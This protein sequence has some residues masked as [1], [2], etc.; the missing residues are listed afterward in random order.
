MSKNGI[1]LYNVIFPVWF[2]LLFPLSWLII[3]PANLLIDSLVLI[4]S[5]KTFK[6]PIKAAWKRAILPVW[7]FGF[8]A[9]ITGAGLLLLTQVVDSDSAVFRWLYE[10]VFN[11]VAFNPFRSIWSV[12]VVLVA[13]AVS[14]IL[15]YFL[16]YKVSFKKLE[17]ENNQK[18]KLAVALAVFTAPWVM[19]IPS[20]WIY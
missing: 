7:A 6:Q 3:L 17:I 20:S 15:I 5:L 9:D 16:N 4:L 10:N 2:L 18:K 1:T 11:Y 19:L 8:L 13:I 14:G 12:L